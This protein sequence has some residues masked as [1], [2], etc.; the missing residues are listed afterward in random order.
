MIG[1]ILV[2][3]ALVGMFYAT[4]NHPSNQKSHHSHTQKRSRGKFAKAQKETLSQT[5][6]KVREVNGEVYYI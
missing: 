5:K 4:I 3:L 2:A 6:I 1:S